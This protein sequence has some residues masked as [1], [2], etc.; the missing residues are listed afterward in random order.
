MAKTILQGSVK[1]TRRG[2]IKHNIKVWSVQ[3][4]GDSLKAA[5]ERE[6]IVAKSSVVP[7]QSVSR[8]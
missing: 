7:R 3:E 5:E 2:N 6:D 4:F 8:N 1:G